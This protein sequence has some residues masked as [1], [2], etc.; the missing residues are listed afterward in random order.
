MG[1]IEQEKEW[2]ISAKGKGREETYNISWV[3][4][5]PWFLHPY[6]LLPPLVQACLS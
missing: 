2:V 3:I 6:D 5:V 4:E 1:A